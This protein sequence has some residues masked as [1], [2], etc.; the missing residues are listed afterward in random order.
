MIRKQINNQKIVTVH[1]THLRRQRCA[2]VTWIFSKKISDGSGARSTCNGTNLL[3][4]P[5]QDVLLGFLASNFNRSLWQRAQY[6]F[7][8]A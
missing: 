8:V 6:P 2:E 5:Q 4:L 3:F 7:F 1:V